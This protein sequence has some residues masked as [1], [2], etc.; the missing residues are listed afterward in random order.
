MVRTLVKSS[1]VLA[2][3][4]TFVAMF[5]VWSMYLM[6]TQL[7]QL[8]INV[9]HLNHSVRDLE[10]YVRWKSQVNREYMISYINSKQPAGIDWKLHSGYFSFDVFRNQT[11][12]H[13]FAN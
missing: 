4:I 7:V 9:A 10:S 11:V 3:G 13:V 2:L 6:Q 8:V 1:T 12:V 5:T